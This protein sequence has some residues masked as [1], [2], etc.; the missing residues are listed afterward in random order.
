MQTSS[1]LSP[2]TSSS[3]IH[4][5]C[6]CHPL[7]PT[8]SRHFLCKHHLYYHQP[9]HHHLFTVCANV[10]L[11]YSSSSAPHCCAHI[12]FTSSPSSLPSYPPLSVSHSTRTSVSHPPPLVTA[13]TGCSFCAGSNAVGNPLGGSPQTCWPTGGAACAS[14]SSSCTLGPC[15]RSD[16][17]HLVTCTVNKPTAQNHGAGNKQK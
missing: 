12:I 11:Y 1:S 9:H 8:S 2:A 4:C 10:I 7:L 6:K 15:C 3:S 14:R 13:G 17:S 5:L 16:R